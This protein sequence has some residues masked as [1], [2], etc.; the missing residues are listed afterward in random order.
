[1]MHASANRDGR[2]AF[3]LLE[4]QCA[5][6][7]TDLEMFVQ[8][9]NW[10]DAN[11]QDASISSCVGIGA[12]S[13]TMFSGYL[14]GLNARH[15]PQYR[16]NNDELSLKLLSC[17]TADHSPTLAMEAQKELRAAP[18]GRQFMLPNGM[19]DFG[20]AVHRPL[21]SSGE[22]SLMPATSEPL[23]STAP[24]L[25]L[26]EPSMRVM[27]LSLPPMPLLMVVRN[28]S[29]LVTPFVLSP[30]VGTA[31]ALVTVVRTAPLL[32]PFAPL[33]LLLT[34][35]V[36]ACGRAAPKEKVLAKVVGVCVAPAVAVDVAAMLL[37]S[38]LTVMG[39]CTRLT[40]TALIIS[41]LLALFPPML[42]IIPLNLP[43]DSTCM[44][45]W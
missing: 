5:R 8:D 10:Q 18:F 45:R 26:M 41:P 11:W 17:I 21:T 7:I 14:T 36:A 6:Q 35:C 15:P 22:L 33:V 40:A 2:L 16:K 19:R 28:E 42:L 12:D 9:K 34:C 4:Q 20:G 30:R 1:M 25:V 37:A 27:K 43:P 24:P 32:S 29:C 38:S 39:M 23:P 44:M 13:I 3:Q 31:V